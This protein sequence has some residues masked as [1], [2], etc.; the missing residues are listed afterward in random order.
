MKDKIRVVIVDDHA[1][2]REAVAEV[3]RNDPHIKIIGQ[4]ASAEEAIR[5]TRE[6]S[7]DILLLD[8]TMPGGGM[9][10]AAVIVRD[11]PETKIVMLTASQREDDILKA[12]RVGVCA[13]ILKGVTG[14]KLVNVIRDVSVG[15]CAV[16][17]TLMID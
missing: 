10:S 8:I 11:Y 17:P 6:L 16:S 15:H 13:Y 4:G 1:L 9:N 14:R 12:F 2:F 7:P 3:L 5:L